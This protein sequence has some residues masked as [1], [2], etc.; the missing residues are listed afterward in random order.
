MNKNATHEAVH[1]I[2]KEGKPI[3]SIVRNEQLRITSV[4]LLTP[5]SAE[6]I[7]DLI[8]DHDEVQKEAT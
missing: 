2:W 1:L 6:E 5:A 4:F 8:V 7:A 3:A